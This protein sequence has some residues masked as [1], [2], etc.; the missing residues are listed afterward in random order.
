MIVGGLQRITLTD[1][2]DHLSAVIFTRGCNF[3]CP[4][5][6][7][8]ELVE[9]RVY[10]EPIPL[11]DVLTFLES[12]VGRLEGVVVTGGEPTVHQ[13][14][15]DLLRK[16]RLL[17]LSIKLDTNG[18]AP[19]MLQQLIAEGLLD[20]VAL[21][22][23]SSVDSY[24]RA[25]GLPVRTQDIRKSV[26]L[27]ASSGV[28]HELRMTF[29]EPFIPLEELYSVANLARGCRLFLVQPFQPSKTLDPRLLT[30]GRPS[31]EKLEQVRGLLQAFGLPA[32]RR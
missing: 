7:N 14:L 10:A 3:R 4:Y 23:K 9:P 1:Y 8:P 13:D 15:P 29:V 12:R 6:H 32:V 24:S 2:P 17:G 18:S 20:Y 27:I 30:L 25:T 26:E 22:I 5:C 11:E 16:I 21:D 28:R 19:D 31:S